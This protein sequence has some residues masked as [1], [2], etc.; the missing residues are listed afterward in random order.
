MNHRTYLWLHL[1]LDIIKNSPPDFGKRSDIEK[2]LSHLPPQVSDAYETILSRSKNQLRTGIFLRIMLAATRPLTLDEANFALTLAT[3]EPEPERHADVD[4]WPTNTFQSIVTNLCG[5]FVSVYDS[6]LSFI[7]QTAREFLLDSEQKGSWQGRFNMPQSHSTISR[8]CLL[9]LLLPDINRPSK[10]D[11]A[12]DKQHPYLA[13]AA[14]YWPL[15][16]ISQEDTDTNA[17]RSH[18]HTLCKIAGHQASIWAPSYLKQRHFDW[19]GWTDL[20]LAIYL[21]LR[22][23]VQDILLNENTGVDINTKDDTYRRTTLHWASG[24]GHV[25]IV[26]LLSGSS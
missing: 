5:L 23:V 7:H 19:K 13:Y 9:Y 11:P 25:D 10:D 8:S 6:K 21:G 15:H 24:R 20:A 22:D 17:F 26:K 1:R 3:Q 2:L 18:A 16:F 4:L 14:A 12:Q